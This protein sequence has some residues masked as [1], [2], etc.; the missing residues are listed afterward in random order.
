MQI[1]NVQMTN[2]S[3][4][5]YLYLSRPYWSDGADMIKTTFQELC[6]KNVLHIETRMVEVDKRESRKDIF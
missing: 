3:P 1:K 2:L 5:E 4:T 6:L